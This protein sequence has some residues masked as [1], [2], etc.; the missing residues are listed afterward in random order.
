MSNILAIPIKLILLCPIGLAYG[1][2]RAMD[3]S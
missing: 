2:F 3:I 1:T